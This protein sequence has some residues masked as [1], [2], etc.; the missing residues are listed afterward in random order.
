MSDRGQP[1]E[2][3]AE[4]RERARAERE[5]RRAG[6][7]QGSSEGASDG[8]A[9]QHDAAGSSVG[10]AR[11]A[12]PPPT[13]AYS[14]EDSEWAHEQAELTHEQ[15]ELTQGEDDEALASA[16]AAALARRGRPV[17][18]RGPAR[19]L[20]RSLARQAR[21]QADRAG[22]RR[23]AGRTRAAAGV[24]AAAGIRAGHWR[25]RRLGRVALVVPIA[26]LIAVAWFLASLFQPFAGPGHGSVRITIPR[27]MTSGQIADLLARRGVISSPFFFRLRAQLDGKGGSLEPGSYTL[28]KDMSY[29][30][31]IAIL[32]THRAPTT[33][34]V[35]IPEG[36]SRQE[37]AARV[38]SL[39]L[40]GSYLVASRR[41]GLLDPHAYG[42]PARPPSLEGFLFPATYQLAP[43]TP[44]SALVQQQLI[45]F[46]RTLAMVPMADAR[47]HNLTPWDV[48]VI[49]SMVEREAAVARDRPLIAAVI[50]NRLHDHI[51]L[52][53]DATLRYALN[54]W[55]RSLTVSELRNPSPYNTRIHQGLPPG[56]IGNPGLASLEAAANPAHVGYLYYVVKPGGCGA[57]VF[58]S[59]Y[60]QFLR[61]VAAYDRA[62]ATG[63]SPTAC[64][65]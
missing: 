51:P 4:E 48:V 56:P 46:R 24:R 64:A 7:A 44:V 40:R 50:W 13:E 28:R 42:G 3:T 57:H 19:T 22:A 31:V 59:S 17:R 20:G 63:K 2:R 33:V 35:T 65:R 41:S 15:T 43:G 8:V 60:S 12:D 14:V 49:A 30:S 18:A 16:H 54:D 32:S 47:R 38:A 26:L 58:S 29:A 6:Q 53:I 5:A 34:T 61:D 52:G 9:A 37:I 55:T 1:R 27:G 45:A 10:G 23:A 62:L 21:G 11:A 25:G 39:D 36:L